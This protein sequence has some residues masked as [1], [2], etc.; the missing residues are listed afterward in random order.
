MSD[1]KILGTKIIDGEVHRQCPHCKR[2]RALSCFGL[3]TMKARTSDGVDLVT[4]Q[5]WC[6]ECR[7][8][9]RTG[10]PL[11]GSQARNQRI[12]L[13]V[14]VDTLQA[15]DSMCGGGQSRADIIAGLINAAAK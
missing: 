5:S 10:R 6:R 8:I 3:R 9:K 13:R 11:K 7:S 15:L 1:L 14:D 4:N 2:L 12:T